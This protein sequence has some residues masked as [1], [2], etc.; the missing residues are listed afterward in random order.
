MHRQQGHEALPSAEAIRKRFGLPWDRVL[1]LATTKPS[2]RT[3]LLGQ[4]DGTHFAGWGEDGPDAAT[5]A[6]RSVALRVGRPPTAFEYDEAAKAIEAKSA[7]RR[8]GKPLL[9]PRSRYMLSVHESWPAVL[10]E[11]G[12]E[13]S[14]SPPAPPPP[15]SMS[16]V[17]D[18][19]IDEFGVLPSGN[20][21]LEWSRRIN[22]PT[23]RIRQ[24]WDEVVSEVRG[25][26][27]ARGAL[28]PDRPTRGKDLPPLPDPVP[29]VRRM[30]FRHSRAAILD[31]LR[32]YGALHLA[33]G[34][35]PRQKHYMAAGRQDRELI[36]PGH[37]TR[38]GRFHDLCVEAGIEFA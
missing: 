33:P 19:F 5:R 8:S 28:T 26:R 29:R 1:H 10:Q 12:L 14:P 4:W 30:P 16:Q 24:G 38:F 23:P 22:I 18:R 13:P 9:L 36:W 7:Q 11:A 31:S 27:S 6:L 20:Y 17:L 34:C 3:R 32:R 21:L 15:P 25:L 37:F 35:M 2:H